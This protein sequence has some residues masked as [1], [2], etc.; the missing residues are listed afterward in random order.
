MDLVAQA[1]AAGADLVGP[2]GLMAPLTKRVLEV[3]LEAEMVEWQNRPLDRR[4]YPVVFV[5]A[6][7]VKIR[8]GK[9]INRPVYVAIG[10]TTNGDWDILG[11]WAGEDSQAGEGAKFSWWV[12]RACLIWE[13]S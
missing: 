9:V 6:I 4:V 5:D 13:V 11:L 10:V 12:L 1:R 2:D 7:M 3:A 8:D